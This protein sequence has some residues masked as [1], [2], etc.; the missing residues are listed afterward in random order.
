M[1]IRL[2][3]ASDY[4]DITVGQYRDYY[5]AKN[6]VERLMAICNIDKQ[7]AQQIPIN[8]IPTLLAVFVEGL[9][10]QSQKFNPIIT[11]GKSTYGFIPN[12]YN[13]TLA[14][15]ADAVELC[16]DLPKNIVLLAGLFYRPITKQVGD[17]Y[18]IAK[19][20]PADNDL[21][22]EEI[23]LMTLEYFNGLMLFFWTL[24]NELQ[25]TSADYLSQEIHQM[26]KMATDLGLTEKD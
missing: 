2:S 9:S 11:L 26:K 15:Y 16:K 18:Q 1:G 7:Q 10:K 14:E 24:S 19:Y 25:K 13:M 20:D 6:D 5:A 8:H 3:I 22:E 12:L 23:K 17:K 4:E 21:R